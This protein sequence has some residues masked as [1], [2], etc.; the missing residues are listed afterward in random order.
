MVTINAYSLKNDGTRKLSPHF[1]VREFRCKDGTD[2]IF[3]APDLVKTL[4]KI[5]VH[6]GRAVIINSAYR[7]T[8]HNSSVGGKPQSQHLYGTAADIKIEGV[9]PE[10]VAAYARSIMPTSGGV[11][12]YNT[13][14]H[15]D[16]R[17]KKSDWRG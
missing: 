10:K 17:E 11:G 4:E 13:F 14:T 15:V 2:P 8:S 5:R 12:R 16:V 1:R 3:V 6:F 9:P 7:T